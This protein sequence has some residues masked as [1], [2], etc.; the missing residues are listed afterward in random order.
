MEFLLPALLMSI[1][2]LSDAREAAAVQRSAVILAPE[3]VGLSGTLTAFISLLSNE[4]T[5]HPSDSAILPTASESRAISDT[6]IVETE[7]VSI[8]WLIRVF[9]TVSS[10]KSAS[11]LEAISKGLVFL[12][13]VET[14]KPDV[15]PKEGQKLVLRGKGKA[16]YLGVTGNSRKGRDYISVQ[17]YL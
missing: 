2:P 10:A 8:S 16:I 4:V 17:K 14:A 5:K 7:R 9:L 1:L 11:A 13:G 12:D 3:Y 15:H 6:A